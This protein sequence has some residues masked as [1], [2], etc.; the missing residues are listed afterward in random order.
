METRDRTQQQMELIVEVN[1]RK[2]RRVCARGLAAHANYDAETKV[3]ATGNNKYSLA[4]LASEQRST[5][6][7]AMNISAR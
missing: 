4:N 3:K 5:M 1:E 7:R 6:R 2:A